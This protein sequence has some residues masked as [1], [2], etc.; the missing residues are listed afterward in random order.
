MCYFI[1]IEPKF[2]HSDL[3]VVEAEVSAA[4]RTV[5]TAVIINHNNN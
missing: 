4:F 2:K 3:D 5:Y 1:I